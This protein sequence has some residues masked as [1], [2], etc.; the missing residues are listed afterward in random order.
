MA[1][2]RRKRSH[3]SGLPPGTPVHIGVQKRDQ[4]VL[5]VLTY[6][7]EGVEEKTA[8][9]VS[10]CVQAIGDPQL[11]N[12]GSLSS[13]PHFT[14][15]S[16]RGLHDIDLLQQLAGVLHI[17][18]LVVEDIANTEQRP[19]VEDFD[20]YNFLVL[21]WIQQNP[22]SKD[23]VIEQVS[24]I[25]GQNFLVSFEEG[26]DDIFQAV[27]NRIHVG[28]GQIR[29]LGTDYLAY[30]LLDAV[31][32]HYFIV[33]ESLGEVIEDFEDELIT[34]S[35]PDNLHKLHRLKQDMILLRKAVWPCREV[36]AKLERGESPLLTSAT[37][38]YFRDV[39]D[40]TIQVIETTETYRDM[41]AGMLDIYLSSISNK[42]NETMKVL[43]MI[44]TIFIPLTFISGVY[45][46]N[47]RY[48][49][50]LDW[51]WGYPAVVAVMAILAIGMLLLF[52]RKRWF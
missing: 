9:S 14:W 15:I 23:L 50:E 13:F 26:P 12:N 48:M 44:A 32:D 25:Q 5:R 21:K 36:I 18:P 52:R 42:L 17:H 46:M 20:A 22:V 30:T 1:N 37:G 29:N 51:P 34:H 43:T 3:K 19:K 11:L 16:V 8:S 49:P 45:G 33:L 47:F 24:M 28:K 39:Y 40:H 35:D 27:R 41:L 38:I 4:P 6:H 31:V 10:E 7:K 2:S